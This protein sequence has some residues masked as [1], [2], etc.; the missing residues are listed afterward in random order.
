[1]SG[2][3]QS[4]SPPGW[5]LL[6]SDKG[7]K[8]L[9]EITLLRDGGATLPAVASKLRAQYADRDLIAAALTQSE[10]RT[11]ALPKFGALSR[12]MLF[13]Q[14]GL[15]QASRMRVAEL[16]ADRFSQAGC[17]SVSDLGSGLG[18]ESL[19]FLRAGM[20][21]HA[22]EIDPLTAAFAEHNL[23]VQSDAL[24]NKELA[25]AATSAASAAEFAVQLGDATTLELPYT[26]GVFLDP[27]RRSA[28]HRD[29]K[30]LASPNDYSPTLDF[31]FEAARDARAGGVKLGP[32]LDRSLIPED[33]EAQ[34]VSVDGVL[35]EMGLW[36]GA[37]ARSDA[38][39]VATV[40]QSRDESVHE[41][42]AKSD[43][44]DAPVRELG[45]Y[46][47]EPDGAIIRARLI[48]L[49]GGMLDAG[50]IHEHIAYLTADRHVAT[51][52]GQVF[53]IVE[54]LPSRE[55]DLKRALQARGIGRLEIKKRGVDV[56]PAA[57]RTRLRLKGEGS[58]ILILSRSASKHIALLAERC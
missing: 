17:R 51:S 45:E 33:A 46:L 35:V 50:M 1:M 27:A 44:E 52:F 6:T 42:T 5:D 4:A 9:F 48:G 30:R 23:T 53:R 36:F 54:E 2:Q 7:T 41:L 38:R 57:L 56:D 22:I 24:R 43:T 29:T 15:E 13:T 32:G 20:H 39:R 58:A 34:W 18:A 55:K 37:A 19:A 3:A 40:V 25:S 47:I 28:G 31:A 12:E 14:A 49:L 11:K 16:H 8:L 26:D 10:L 21:V